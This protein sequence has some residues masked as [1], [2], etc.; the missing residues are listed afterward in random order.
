MRARLT[1]HREAIESLQLVRLDG[2]CILVSHCAE[3]YL[4][5]TALQ[6]DK[7]QCFLT[8]YCEG[9]LKRTLA[10][11]HQLALVFRRGVF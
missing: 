9:A 8:I 4:R 10:F 5:F 2:D 11:D 7:A 6:E 3:D 1:Y